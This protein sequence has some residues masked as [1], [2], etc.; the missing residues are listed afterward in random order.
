MM[1]RDIPTNS[2]PAHITLSI[3]TARAEPL[4][5]A[6]GVLVAVSHLKLGSIEDLPYNGTGYGL[7]IGC[8]KQLGG[9]IQWEFL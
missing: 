1:N 2:N 9:S 3:Y 4:Y 7:R 5:Q 8:C 6:I